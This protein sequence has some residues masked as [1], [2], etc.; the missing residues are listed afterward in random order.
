VLAPVEEMTI[1]GEFAASPTPAPGGWLTLD[2]RWIGRHIVT[3]PVPILGRVTC[4]R[5]MIPKL[6][7]ILRF[8]SRKG[9]SHLV[10][11]DDYGGCF[12]PRLIPSLA[13]TAISHHAWGSAIDLNV[14]DNLFGHRPHQDP[15][16]VAAFARWGF[17]WGGLFVVPDGMH[18]EYL[19]SS[20]SRWSRGPRSSCLLARLEPSS[21]RAG[22]QLSCRSVDRPRPGNP[23]HPRAV[24]VSNH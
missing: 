15:R 4:D 17:V 18:F 16:L 10:H 21:D 9:L 8:L 14:S 12:A 6:R 5:S 19:G 3:A 13:G 23:R 22:T 11:P 2:P 1:F 7:A 20:C 24:Y